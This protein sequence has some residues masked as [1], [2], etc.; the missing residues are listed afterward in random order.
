MFKTIKIGKPFSPSEIIDFSTEEW[1]EVLV[2]YGGGMGGVSAK[3]YTKSDIDLNKEFVEIINIYGVKITLNT[4]YI[5]RINKVNVAFLDMLNNGN[6]Y[7]GN[8][9]G[10]TRYIYVT[11]TTDTFECIS[12]LG[13]TSEQDK[14]LLCKY[15]I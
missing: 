2:T 5:V 10:E 14:Y 3:H 7:M 11:S 1:T 4:R 12:T 9:G 8:I 6:Q 13:N 15:D